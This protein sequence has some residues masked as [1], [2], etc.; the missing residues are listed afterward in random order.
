MND[1]FFLCYVETTRQCNLHCQ[2]C[3]SRTA[4]QPTRP[5]LSTYEVKRLV[6]D[7]LAKVSSRMA[8]AF[9]GGE[10]LLR[11]DAY[12]LLAYTANLGM[13]SFVN[14]NGKLLVETDAV[15]RAM[16]SS[17]GKVIFVL[18][19][20]SVNEVSNRATRD[21]G[22]GTVL[23]ASDVCRAEGADYFFLVTVSR[24]NLNTLA[25]TISFLKMNRV[26]MLRAPFVPRGAGAKCADLMTGQEE[27]RDTVHP[28]LS[29][30]PL[31]YISFTPFFASPEAMRDTWDRFAVRIEGLGCHAGRSFAAVGAEGHVVPCVQL[32]DSAVTTANVRDTPLAE[33]IRDHPVFKAL[34]RRETLQG[35][36]GRCRYRDTCGGCRAIAYY[37][38]GDVLAEDPT[39]FFDP[40]SP[41][42]RS[43]LEEM[44]TAQLGKFV[45]YVKYNS[46]W[47]KLFW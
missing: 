46:P 24:M 2:Y 15:R 23:R 25:R 39:C 31:S 22:T 44:Q 10:H 33:I 30:N 34:R 6:L 17:Q 35:K 28:A 11:P 47:N 13:W 43:E 37:R 1:N 9:S 8:V 18:P 3:M 42:E 27:M 16:D 12:E 7:E 19:I 40:V 4:V 41:A 29:A 5:E 32:L 21:D 20:N 26:P 45:D 14:T 36:C 38:S